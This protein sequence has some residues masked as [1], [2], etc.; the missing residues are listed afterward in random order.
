[1]FTFGGYILII[2]FILL[3]LLLLPL[4]LINGIG[5]TCRANPP[6]FVCYASTS[7]K[8]TS[9]TELVLW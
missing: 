5:I 2:V 4:P 7:M 8:I 9:S 6:V 1:M 3:L